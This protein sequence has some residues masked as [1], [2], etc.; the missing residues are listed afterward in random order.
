MRTTIAVMLSSPPRPFAS[1]MSA[2]TTRCAV[3]R[4]DNR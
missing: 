2:S 1:E 4:E 3:A